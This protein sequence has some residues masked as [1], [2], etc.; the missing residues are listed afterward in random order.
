MM[1]SSTLC[2]SQEAFH[3]SR[4]ASTS[5]INVRAIAEK[6]AAAWGAEGVL[7]DLREQRHE[8]TL[9]IRSALAEN[10]VALDSLFSENADRGLAS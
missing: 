8:R 3:R 5:L 7:A 1:P 4:A 2:R 10:E 9:S 6:A